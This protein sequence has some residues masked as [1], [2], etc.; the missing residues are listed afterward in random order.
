MPSIAPDV[1]VMVDVVLH[2]DRHDPLVDE[3]SNG[4]LNLPLLVG[5]G[6]IHRR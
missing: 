4:V 3:P 5:Q 6:E 1:E 2:G